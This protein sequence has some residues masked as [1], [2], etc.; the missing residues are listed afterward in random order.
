MTVEADLLFAFINLS[1]AINGDVW[2]ST[3]RYYAMK[4]CRLHRPIVISLILFFVIPLAFGQREKNNIYLFDCT[5]SMKINGLWEPAKAALDATICAQTSIPGSQFCIIPFGDNPYEH[6]LFDSDQY[7]GQKPGI[8]EAFGKHVSKASYTRISDVL[9]AGFSKVDPM[10]ENKIY[11]LTD[12]MPNGG[13]SPEKVAEAIMAWCARHRNCRL[14]YVALTNGVVNP[15]IQRA[16]DACS[17]AFIVQCEK[18]VI[19]QIADIYP[20]NLYTNLEELSQPVEILFSI[21]GRYPLS[22]EA[23]DSLFDVKVLEGS[24]RDGR[25]QILLNAKNGLDASRI[26]QML[27]GGEYTIPVRL[28]CSDT[29][30]FIANPDITVYVSDE[31]PAALELAQGEHEITA[32]G[33]KWHDSYLWSDAAPDEKIEWDLAPVF[34]NH[35]LNTNLRLRFQ[36]NDGEKTDFKAW[37][38]GVPID[39]GSIIAIAPGSPSLLEVAFDHDAK[40]GKRYFS[41]APVGFDSLDM[42]NGQPSDDYQGTSLR[43]EYEI[44]WNPLQTFFF[45]LALLVL[46]AALLW[47]AFLRRMFFPTIKMAKVEITGPGTYYAT[48]KIKGARKVVLSSKKKRQNIFSRIFTGEIRYVRADHFIPELSILAA[49]GKKKV[50]FRQDGAAKDKWDVF[51]SSIFGQFEK[52]SVS[53]QDN[54]EKFDVEFS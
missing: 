34:K 11:L 13:D 4:Y 27:Q 25:I 35:L 29:R 43:T 47:F 46:A 15:A 24:A 41:L 28:Q 31:I 51:P 40:T 18:K 9:K 5:G 7:E 44:G 21:P 3:N 33:V 30:Y 53:K 42:I 52:G 22:V 32:T 36:G 16:I 45:W 54:N 6:I 37:Y 19:P 17:D 14:F 39:N 8:D 2:R 38:N 10:K 49:G 50:K 20:S 48:K 1:N 12:G 26:H 23:N